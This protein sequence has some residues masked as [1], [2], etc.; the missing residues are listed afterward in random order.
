MGRSS[1]SLV[2]IDPLDGCGVLDLLFRAAQRALLSLRS[3]AF[4]LGPLGVVL[5]SIVQCDS[6]SVWAGDL[7]R[8]LKNKTYNCK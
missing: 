3:L 6:A 5:A 8:R 4:V 2:S 1:L 7:R